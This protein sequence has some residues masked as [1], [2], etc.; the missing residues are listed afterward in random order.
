MI[1]PVPQLALNMA[2]LLTCCVLV[3]ISLVLGYTPIPAGEVLRGLAG[4]ADPKTVTI[5]QDL[6]LPRTALAL[7]IG[8]SLG[9]SGAALQGLLQNPLAEPGVVGVSS[10]AAFG[11]VLVIYF[12]LAAT[13][14]WTLP[15]SGMAGA[16]AATTIL[17]ALA[18]R[19]AAKLTLLLT[20]V[21]I[22]GLSIA[23]ISLVM[24]LSSN[25]WAISEVAFW[26]MGSLKDRTLSDLGLAAPFI[27]IGCA[28]LIA[29][30]G[31]LEALTLGE[32][33]A[34]SLGTPVNRVRMQVVLGTSLCVGAGVSVAGAVG[35]VGLI[36]PH[37]LRAFTDH[38]PARLLLP[39]ALGGAAL[40]LT[41]DIAIRLIAVGPELQL[42]VVT[43]LIGAPFFFALIFRL[44]GEQA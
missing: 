38:A 3:V 11:A 17:W 12:G 30:G 36:V 44:Q 26:L 40:L 29:S 35:F 8:G 13:S 39:S 24:N 1:R 43:S 31:G 37:L 25:P 42:G 33:T 6:R 19:G 15:L 22:G 32:D 41:A 21:A 34:R 5:V 28:M 4:L 23:L 27:L 7:L 2:L 9:L 10:A 14:S 16:L 18:V 20:G